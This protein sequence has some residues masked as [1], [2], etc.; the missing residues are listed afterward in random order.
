[1]KKILYVIFGICFLFPVFAQQ[2]RVLGRVINERKE[3]IQSVTIRCIDKDSTFIEGCISDE[4]GFFVFSAPL[5]TEKYKL[6]FSFMGYKNYIV[7]IQGGN[8]N[9]QLG[10]IML[11]PDTKQLN[12]VVVSG[13][14]M[15]RTTDKIVFFP[16][17]EQLR[18]SSDGYNALAT[19]MIPSLDVDPFTKKVSTLRGN[20]TLLING[21]EAS[22]E[23]VKNLNP[24]DI[25]RIDFYDQHHPQY[26]LA[27]SVVDYILVHRDGGGSVALNGL[28]HLNKKNGSYSG[29]GQFFKKKSELALY[30]N[31]SYNNY[32]SDRGTESTTFLGF[33]GRGITN[34][35]KSLPSLQ[36]SNH[37][38]SY[39]NYLYQDK[40]TQF[41]ASAI[42]R[43]GN[44]D[45]DNQSIQTYSN[46]D[47]H[48]RVQDFSKSQ[49]L[50]PALKLSLNRNMANNQ[51]FRASLLGSYN[52]NK[53]DRYYHAFENNQEANAY[54]TLANENFFNISPSVMYVKTFS[55]KNALF[56]S[57][58][59]DYTHT[60]TDYLVDGSATEDDQT[61]TNGN[62]TLGYAI[63]MVKNLR[64]TLQVG[65]Y[66]HTFDNGE[67]SYT[68]YIFR[69]GIFFFYQLKPGH[70]LN[71]S[72]GIGSGGPGA[73]YRAETEQQLDKYQIRK[74][75]PNI[76]TAKLYTAT[77]DYMWD[78]RY[79]TLN[80]TIKYDQTEN[81]P[82][83][84]V[85]YN[86]ERDLFVHDYDPFGKTKIFMTGPRLRVKIIP[87]KLT[88]DLSGYYYYKGYDYWKTLTLNRI[89]GAAKLMFIHKNIVVSAQLSTPKESYEN[90]YKV[91]MPVTYDFN[92]GYT[93]N[94][95]HFEFATR[96]PFSKIVKEMD[97]VKD[98]YNRSN[99]VYGFRINDHVFYTTISYR[100]NFGKKHKFN[101]VQIEDTGGTT[102]L[103]AN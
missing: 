76:E 74:G 6:F 28:Q 48:Y 55:N 71:A 10:D 100:F 5:Q 99:R 102:I 53:Y 88:L 78:S 23:E 90:G 96:N 56:V 98:D 32:V 25:L 73:E 3:P 87:R 89:E 54:T 35:Q 62:V 34:D 7:E 50:N 65:N 44:A 75:N 86:A 11:L 61:L 40:L 27:N 57:A 82:Y 101:N 94:N 29:T 47:I 26:P 17:K 41:Y 42:F 19:M 39:I 18:N 13:T 31:D 83:S 33:P 9:L 16:S 67:Q 85:T 12:E 15:T 84:R 21:R 60:N 63:R 80:Y 66:L 69:P 45:N 97:Y 43:H 1:M 49:N 2:T 72:L 46:E 91:S 8:N 4:R 93:I 30:V 70:V 103:K 59:Y 24:K 95:W 58:S 68:K 79:T 77:F 14:Q 52:N 36:K 51:I 22:S 20:T 64:L 37:I 38:N 92:M 81:F